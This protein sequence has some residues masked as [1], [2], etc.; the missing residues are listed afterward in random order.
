MNIYLALR[1]EIEMNLQRY[2]RFTPE[3]LQ[4]EMGTFLCELAS[5]L[6]WAA[7]L[8]FL[9][10]RKDK[11]PGCFLSLLWL[12]N[13]TN[14][15]L[16]VICFRADHM[17]VA[18][19]TWIACL[20]LEVIITVAIAGKLGLVKEGRKLAAEK[21]Q[22]AHSLCPVLEED[23]T[24]PEFAPW[25]FFDGCTTLKSTKRRYKTYQKLLQDNTMK[26]ALILGQV[27]KQYQA[28]IEKYGGSTETLPQ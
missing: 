10:Y 5:T 18:S 23:G 6:I 2:K 14:P 3:M 9:L 13:W 24:I 27:Y 8:S 21:V 4:Y 1:E 19:N 22:L 11:K 28:E 7:L 20:V 12:V 16:K 15:I 17:I 26:S 25:F